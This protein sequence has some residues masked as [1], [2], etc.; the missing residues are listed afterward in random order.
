MLPMPST[1]CLCLH[2]C[3]C[4]CVCVW[5]SCFI[6]PV[7]APVFLAITPLALNFVLFLVSRTYF[8]ASLCRYLLSTL[9]FS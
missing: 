4:V 9:Q 5:F 6:F 1:L 2:A 7:V 8:Q 3:E